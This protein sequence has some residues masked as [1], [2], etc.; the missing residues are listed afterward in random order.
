LT[1]SEERGD[2]N[3]FAAALK[4][5]GGCS[6]TRLFPIT[7]HPDY[8]DIVMADVARRDGRS[9]VRRW[10]SVLSLNAREK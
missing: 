8:K 5:L 2:T 9:G 6:W 7:L 3:S 10:N 1:F 4:L